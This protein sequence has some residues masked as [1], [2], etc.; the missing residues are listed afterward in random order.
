MDAIRFSIE[1]PVTVIVGV[2]LVVLFGYIGLF[3][4]PY[5]LTPT[6]TEPEIAVTTVWSGATPYEIERE[7]VEEQEKVLKGIPGLIEMESSSVNNRGTVT[8]RFQ[9]GTDVDDA[10]LRVSNKLDEV[11]AYPENVDKPIINATGAATSPVIWMILK[12]KENNHRSI[13]TY[14][15]YFENEV[16]QHLERVEGVADLFIGG[17]TET[18]MHITVRPERLA[19][20]GLTINGL[21]DVLRGENVNVSAGVM[22][23][24]RRDFRIRTVGEFSSVEEIENIIVKSTGQK[25]ILLSD[26]AS[27]GIGHEKFNVAMIHNGT[28][29]IAVG[30]KPEPGTNILDMTDRANKVVLWLNENKL[31]PEN[32]YLDWVYDQR[33]YIRGAIDLV[34]KNIGIGGF[35][36]V[37]V[38][39]IFLRSFSSTVVVATAIPISIFGAFIFMNAFGRNLNVISLAGISFAVG[40]LV[41]NAIVVLE[42][43]DR[44]RKMGKGPFEASYDGTKEVWGAILAST[45]TTVAVFLPVVF[46][47]EEAGQLFRDIAIAV[48]CAVTLSLFVS[49]SVI[50][51][52]SKQLFSLT[53]NK[54]A[55]RGK[56]LVKVGNRIVDWMMGLVSFSLKSR[57][58]QI[59]TV[60]VLTAFSAFVVFMLWPKMEYLPQGNRNLVISILI[61]PPGLSYEERKEIGD[62]IFDAMKPHIGQDID[63]IP[64]IRNLFY[65]GTDFIMLFGAT[66]EHIQRA[67][68]LVPIFSGVI[69]TI[70]G[71]FGVSQQRGIFETRIGRGRTIDVDVSGP[72]LNRVVQATGKMFGSIR[73]EIPAAQ[74]RPIPSLELSYPEIQLVPDR[75]RLRASGMT[76]ADLGIALDVL[77]DGREVGEFKKE[78]EK[79]IDLILKGPEEDISTPEELYRSQLVTPAGKVVPVSSL[80][81]LI[82]TTGMN[83]LRHLERDRT[84]TLQVTPP[85]NLPFQEGMEI[86]N[87]KIIGTLKSQGVLAGVDV[88]MSGAADK[89]TETLKSL[90]W[91]FILAALLAYL[92]MA[93]LFANFIYPLIIMFTVPLAGAGGF[94]AIGLVKLIK[95]QPPD[96]LTM[97]GFIILVGIVVN[98]AILIVHQALNNI[99]FHYMD[100]RNAV[101]ESVK[102]RLRPIYM[103]ATTSIFGM[104]PLVVAPGPGSELYRGLGSVILG[105]LALSTVFTIFVTPSLLLFIMGMIGKKKDKPLQ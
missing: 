7:I 104:L 96:I 22:G 78:G 40:M 31:E 13:S 10:L 62:H 72:D 47:K 44:H 42:N 1:K 3:N 71:M 28:D 77:M 64:A 41:D 90:Q 46:V 99:R 85:G 23:V 20:Y 49:I 4:M 74:V 86:I 60:L 38:L 70:P 21:I 11:R 93:S 56:S 33:P 63:G 68:E 84:I 58:T 97:L 19:S 53:G 16:R 95:G 94:I 17:G 92:L 6:V 81:K 37:T 15:T 76:A 12:S 88:G 45:L 48:T 103:S 79:K 43:I 25:R 67:G 9:V 100:H 8:L 39:L 89:L 2:I 54:V 87:E 50:P 26:V 75:D 35:L 36:A 66:S 98:N 27:V 52:F 30:V 34:K 32:I 57:V 105:G 65:V 102:S 73:Q 5:Q 55:T 69:N 101:L 80:A 24:G 59:A 61:P 14:R 91:N 29:G 83:E 82:R 51:M 18:E